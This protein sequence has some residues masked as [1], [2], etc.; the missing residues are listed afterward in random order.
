MHAFTPLAQFGDPPIDPYTFRFGSAI[1]VVEYVRQDA[2]FFYGLYPRLWHLDDLGAPRCETRCSSCDGIRSWPEFPHSLYASW[3]EGLKTGE[4]PPRWLIVEPWWRP[5]DGL[6]N[7]GDV[8]CYSQIAELL[9][10]LDVNLV[11]AVLI[12]KDRGSWWS[13]HELTTGS[14]KWSV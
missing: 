4:C 8:A 2:Y 7:E 12:D 5:D 1:D 6:P 3:G 10:D 14:T 13:M 9:S 11:D